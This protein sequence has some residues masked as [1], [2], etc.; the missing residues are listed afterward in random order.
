MK[1]I[2]SLDEL[3]MSSAPSLY[4][5]S[6]DDWSYI[7]NLLPKDWKSSCRSY[8]VLKGNRKI[9]CHAILLRVLFLHIARGY[10]LA[11]TSVRSKLSG[12]L[13]ISDV[14]ILN[15]LQRGE[16][17]LKDMCE[18]LYL[19]QEAISISSFNKKIR[20]IDG[21]IVREPGKTGSQWRINYSFSLPNFECDYFDLV[22]SKGK[23][24]GESIK[25]YPLQEGECIIA[26]RNYSIAEQIAYVKESKADII[27]RFNQSLSLYQNNVKIDLLSNLASLKKAG[28]FK[29]LDVE[30]NNGDNVIE[31]RVCAIRKDKRAIDETIKKIKRK[32]SKKS[33]K[34][35]RP[36]TLEYA[37]Y[38][39]VFTTLSKEEYSASQALEWYRIRWQI[40]L[41]FKRLKSIISLSHL[42]KKNDRSSKAWIYGKLLIGLLTEKLIR[43]SKT[44]SPWGYSFKI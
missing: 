13:D 31:G 1:Q 33:T 23:G 30:I 34:N 4:Q 7:E 37:K 15:I 24:N 10:S 42:P 5:N 40:E 41:V 18:K 17:W 6:D 32:A 16:L 35:I 12:L 25:R 44:I 39:I 14:G 9:K 3:S 36:Q 2:S 8:D 28:D 22:S 43:Y 27:V 20:L 21:T 11:E 38:I 19:E 29:E 26:D